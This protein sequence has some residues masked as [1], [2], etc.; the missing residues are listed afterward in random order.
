MPSRGCSN[1]MVPRLARAKIGFPKSRVPGAN[2][3]TDLCY[4]AVSVG[5]VSGVT[6][7]SR[8]R[9]RGGIRWG[10]IVGSRS[11]IR[12][13]PISPDWQAALS[14]A[15]AAPCCRARCRSKLPCRGPAT[16]R[17]PVC[18]VHG[19]KSGG[20]TGERNGAYRTGRYTAEAKADRQATRA[21]LTLFRRLI[22]AG[23]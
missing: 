12:G 4:D 18:R 2:L 20:P 16:R 14:F 19:G 7:S 1:D 6:P 17:R 8:A 9:S 22:D 11:E 23:D 5:R 10:A 15:R 13:D 21:L 3:G